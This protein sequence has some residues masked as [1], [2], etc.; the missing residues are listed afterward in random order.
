MTVWMLSKFYTEP[1]N[2]FIWPVAASYSNGHNC[3]VHP[4][5]PGAWAL[6]RCDSAPPQIEAAG[7][8][9]R[10]QPYRTLWDTITPETVDAYKTKGAAQGMMLGQLLQILAQIEPGYMGAGL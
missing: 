9:P 3:P 4:E 10:V 1:E 7:M 2:N 6:V 8:D 5:T